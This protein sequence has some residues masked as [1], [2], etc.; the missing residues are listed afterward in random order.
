MIIFPAITRDSLLAKAMDFFAFIA[1]MVGI[2][3]AAPT[4]AETTRSISGR[5]AI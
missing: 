1:E 3:P 2:K 5:D 4:K